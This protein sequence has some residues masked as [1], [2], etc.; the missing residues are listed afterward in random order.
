[1]Y[2]P[3]CW[4]CGRAHAQVLVPQVSSHPGRGLSPAPSLLWKQEG[5]WGCAGTEF[6]WVLYVSPREHGM[7]SSTSSAGQTI[8][9]L[10]LSRSTLPRRRSA[11]ALVCFCIEWI[12]SNRSENTKGSAN[13]A[14]INLALSCFHSHLCPKYIYFLTWYFQVGD[15]A[16]HRLVYC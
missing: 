6:A 1:M 13:Y 9:S 3:A 15:K 8:V 7:L 12:T 16:L 4:S 10:S 14:H 5:A 11:S 2:R